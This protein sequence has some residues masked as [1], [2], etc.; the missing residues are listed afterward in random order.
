[1]KK[2]VPVSGV[3]IL[4]IFLSLSV[5]SQSNPDFVNRTWNFF[6]LGAH[7]GNSNIIC[8]DFDGDGSEELLFGGG[9][10]QNNYFTIFSYNNEDYIPIWTSALYLSEYY[11]DNAVAVLLAANFDVDND[12]EIYMINSNGNIEVYN[13][14]NMELLETYQT[15]SEEASDAVFADIDDD[16]DTELV[17]VFEDYSDQY[18]H[19][20]DATTFELEYQTN[21]IGA[22]DVETGDVDG[23]QQTEIILSSGYIIDGSTFET[24]WQY[25]PGFGW[26]TEL[27]DTNGDGIPEII[28][29]NGNY[30]ITAFDG[31]LHTPIWQLNTEYY[32]VDALTVTDLEGDG[33]YEILVGAD[34]FYVAIGCYNASTQALLWENKDEN[35]GVSRIGIGDPDNDGVKEFIW[36]SGVS[37]TVSDHLHIAGFDYYQTEWVSEPFEGHFSVGVYD[38]DADDTLDITI[39][40]YQNDD[41]SE[42]NKILIYNGVNHNRLSSI[43]HDEIYG[44]SCLEVGNINNTDQG[45][46]ITGTKVTVYDGLTFQKLWKSESIGTIYDYELADVDND[47]EIEIIVAAGQSI[48][49]FNGITFEEEW[50]TINTGS[51]IGGVE[52]ENIDG[53]DALEIIFYNQNGIIQAY[54][55]ITHFLEWQ[56]TEMNNVTAIDVEDFNQD[57]VM[58]IISGDYYGDVSFTRCD[59][60]SIIETIDVFEDEIHG[61]KVGNLDSSSHFEIC[62]GENRLKILNANNFELI[63]E[64]PDLGHQ[65]GNYDNIVIDDTDKNQYK[66]VIF[67]TNWGVF[68]Y[69]AST[70]YPDITPPKVI[71]EIP[72]DSMQTVGTNITINVLFSEAMDES[73]I[74]D[75]SVIVTDENGSPVSATI[76]IDDSTNLLTVIPLDNLPT[77]NEITVRLVA[78][79]SDTAGNGLDG[80]NNGIAEGSPEDDF[81]WTFT[82]GQGPD[83]V[84]PVF[85][86]LQADS[87]DKWA[88]IDI[89]V[90]GTLSDS[91]EYASS[92]LADAEYFV[93]IIGNHG[94][95]QKIKATDGHFDQLTEEVESIILTDDWEAGEYVIYFHGKDFIGNWGEYQE[96]EINIQAEEPGCWTMFGCDPQHTGYNSSDNIQLPLNL[97]WSKY[98]SYNQVN[99][100]CIVNEKVIVSANSYSSGNTGLQVLDIENGQVDWYENYTDNTYINPTSFAYGRIYT[101]FIN[102]PN[103]DELRSYDINTGN[104]LWASL[105]GAQFEKYLAPTIADGKIFINGGTYGGAYSFDAFHGYQY[106]FQNLAQVDEWTPAYYN[107]TVYTFT[108]DY[109]L[110]GHLAALNAY[111]GALLWEIKE[112]PFSGY[113]S[114]MGTAPV[115]DT[116]NRVIIVSSSSHQHGIS[117]DTHEILWEKTGKFVSPAI[118]DNVVYSAADNTLSALDI[119]SGDVLWTYSTQEEIA[120]QPVIS[121]DHI[122]ISTEAKVHAVN[123]NDQQQKW[124]YNAGGHLTVGLGYLLVSSFE[125][126]NLYVF[127]DIT[128]GIEEYSPV[129]E[130]EIRLYQNY[131]NPVFDAQATSIGFYLPHQGHVKFTVHNIQG[132]EVAVLADQIFNV[133]EHS[134]IFKNNNLAKGTYFYN[135]NVDGEVFV[136][137]L[138]IL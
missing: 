90:N 20:Y 91:S 73:S 29:S 126:G 32:G 98:L 4:M 72:P 94:E 15:I 13:G 27:G 42:S 36:G 118:H 124:N 14:E 130:T 85:T 110:G 86:A 45:E 129:S 109:G 16:G 134:I 96:L 53:D 47:N 122:F 128:T 107:D 106:W 22:Y 6:E 111:S 103:G 132:T 49:V 17:I 37:S 74:N 56:S 48:R 70:P 52:C 88:G 112:I 65:V 1:M 105:Y 95:G 117:L 7:L 131:P 119:I 79:I 76:S 34:D 135:M 93:N 44:N 10:Y 99:Q 120:Y 46:I 61:L 62:V 116:V 28:S 75:N 77:E 81:V 57:G 33:V 59:D 125:T 54:D 136:K 3:I 50:N 25:V 24:E 64:S 38:L 113:S 60:F 80:N 89:I 84:G 101:Q 55:G 87:Y 133:G 5:F 23:D 19:I 78:S 92:P 67:G 69:E 8:E 102:G 41:Y 51:Q 43:E 123:I 68:Q 58:D 82:T 121:G 97:K 2:E 114:S 63:W 9:G 100:A 127:G 30:F 31:L 35:S 11:N 21:D 137:K 12:F 40:P 66:E 83:I 115:I 108:A 138:V 39:A 71:Y 104:L 18:M 26:H